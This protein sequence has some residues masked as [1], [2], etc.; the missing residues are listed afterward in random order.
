MLAD[1]C[2]YTIK[3]SK[4][5]RASLAKGGRDTYTERKKWVRGKQLLDAAKKLGKRL[6]IMFAPAEGTFHLAA[7]A[8]LEEV[9]PG[10]TT[11]FTFS[12]LRFF[13]KRP[14]KETLRKARDGKPLPRW[15]IRPYAICKTR[16]YLSEKIT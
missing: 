15:F 8:V 1:L 6:A 7:W 5:L 12:G 4:D 11:T 3:H 14:K 16:R 2:V 10:K 13:K 9:L